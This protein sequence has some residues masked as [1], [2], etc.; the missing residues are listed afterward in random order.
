MNENNKTLTIS[1]AAYN[2]ESTIRK[3][4]DSL[5]VPEILDDIEIFVVD[6]GGKDSTLAIA[7]EYEK[8]YPGTVI[9]SHKENGGY[10]STINYS[11]ERAKGKYF[12]Q[13]DGDDWFIQEN[14]AEFVNTLKNTDADCVLTEVAD[15]RAA[16]GEQIVKEKFSEVPEGIHKFEEIKLKNIL[17]MHGTAIKT[18]ILQKHNI[19]IIEH[20]FYSDTELVVLPMPYMNTFYMWKKPLY[21]YLTG[22]EGQ[23]MSISGIKKHYM[24]HDKVFWELCDAYKSISGKEKNKKDLV[25]RR[26]K[27]E[28]IIHFEFI[29]RLEISYK[30]FSE[31]KK[32][33]QKLRDVV[34]D[35][36]ERIYKER[37]NFRTLFKTGYLSYP[38]ASS[39]VKKKY[40]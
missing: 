28:A 15:F 24:D 20:A 23:S 7:Q 35:V 4:L 10:G 27:K 11:V 19:R 21:V 38:I 6:D 9:P 37:R 2:A 36:Y 29:L 16:T 8:K 5:L 33:G 32:F 40:K 13:L 31:V 34:P 12:K 18:E 25:F 30:H 1:I 39:R 22:T 14:F 3:A 26:L 17:T